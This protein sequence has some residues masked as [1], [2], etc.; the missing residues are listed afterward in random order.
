M[1]QNNAMMPRKPTAMVV[2]SMAGWAFSR[3]D[4]RVQTSQ[5]ETP[6]MAA[7]TGNQQNDRATRLVVPGGDTPEV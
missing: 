5:I 7:P 6:S 1:A 3:L 4:Q 2:A